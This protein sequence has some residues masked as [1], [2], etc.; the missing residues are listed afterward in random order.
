MTA[1]IAYKTLD[2][3]D[4]IENRGLVST[5]IEGFVGCIIARGS[6]MQDLPK[7]ACTVQYF[8]AEQTYK[9]WWPDHPWTELVEDYLALIHDESGVADAT[10]E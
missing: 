8:P 6:D 2:L 9:V 10:D 7:A 4:A 3:I 1:T 5:H